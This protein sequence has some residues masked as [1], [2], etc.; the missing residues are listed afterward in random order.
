LLAK[1]DYFAS[2]FSRLKVKDFTRS[3][4]CGTKTLNKIKFV[5]EN[6]IEEY[7]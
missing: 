5:K 6:I 1:V 3:R 7:L 4:V 2:Y